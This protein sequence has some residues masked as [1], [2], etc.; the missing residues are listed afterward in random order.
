MIKHLLLCSLTTDCHR[1]DRLHAIKLFLLKNINKTTTI[2][3]VPS[4]FSNMFFKWT[5]CLFFTFY[6]PIDEQQKLFQERPCF[7][8]R[9]NKQETGYFNSDF[10]V[11]SYDVTDIPPPLYE[12]VFVSS[13]ELHAPQC[14]VCVWG[15]VF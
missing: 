11:Q 4:F 9:S 3:S 15:F 6:T 10:P 12:V 1:N 7:F 2:P 8:Q 5:A 13:H 14:S